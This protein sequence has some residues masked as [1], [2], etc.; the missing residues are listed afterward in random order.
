MNHVGTLL[1]INAHSS[2]RVPYLKK[3]KKKGGKKKEQTKKPNS[4]L[5]CFSSRRICCHNS[6]IT[7]LRLLA[8]L[9]ASRILYLRLLRNTGQT[10]CSMALCKTNAFL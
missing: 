7:L 9:E 1:L 6:V 2:L 8:S 4:T 10:F 3:E 5:M